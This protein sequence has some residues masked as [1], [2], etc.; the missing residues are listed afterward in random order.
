M[1]FDERLELADDV[2]MAAERQLRVDARLTHGQPELLEPRDLTL[3]EPLIREVRQSRATPEPERRVQR[4]RRAARAAGSKRLDPFGR[5]SLEPA[6]V[7]ARGV[8]LQHVAGSARDE[9]GPGAERPAQLGDVD[10]EG[11]GGGR[12]LPVAP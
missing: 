7:Q 4:A 9:A 10:L 11:V 12:R 1:L 2:S 6:G 5:E 3:C 8:D